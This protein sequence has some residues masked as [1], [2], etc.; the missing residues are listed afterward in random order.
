MP[1]SG[2]R[3]RTVRKPTYKV[4][5]NDRQRAKTASPIRKRPAGPRRAVSRSQPQAQG[6]D[7]LAEAA[8][9]A[10]PANIPPPSGQSP[11]STASDSDDQELPPVRT[12][13]QHASARSR[14]SRSLSSS[15]TDEPKE[16]YIEWLVYMGK[17][18][19]YSDVISSDKWDLTARFRS[20]RTRVKATLELRGKD[21]SIS[22]RI[23]EIPVTINAKGIKA[24]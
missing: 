10:E 6:L 22:R 16:Y 21:E 7:Q 19:L 4:V 20:Q 23:A 14:V 9:A 8:S 11:A 17:E 12:I 13:A 18:L 24:L 2:T 5:E 15:S 1:R 3:E